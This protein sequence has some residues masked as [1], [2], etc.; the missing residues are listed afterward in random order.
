MIPLLPQLDVRAI[1]I[2][3]HEEYSLE[4]ACVKTKEVYFSL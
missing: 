1:K 4:H 3:V 2:A